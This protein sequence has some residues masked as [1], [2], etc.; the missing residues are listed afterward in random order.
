MLKRFIQNL[1]LRYKL[2][3]IIVSVTALMLMLVSVAYFFH[4]QQ[5]I[6]QQATVE[7][8]TLSR[9]Y[10]DTCSA[11]ITFADQQ[12]ATDLLNSLVAKPTILAAAIISLNGNIFA[13]YLKPNT[14][15][16]LI[17]SILTEDN[18]N[19]LV[20]APKNKLFH[21]KTP[22]ILSHETIG[23]FLIIA[24]FSD[25]EAAQQ[26]FILFLSILFSVAILFSLVLSSRLQRHITLPIHKLITTMG[27]VAK[28]DDFSLRVH[29]VATDEVGQL[30]AGFNTM[31]KRIEQ[32]SDLLQSQK[33]NLHFLATHDALTGLPN[34]TL[35]NDRLH[36]GLSRAKRNKTELAV[37]FI[38]LD[39]FKNINDTMGHDVGDMLL[40]TVANRLK[41]AVREDDTVSRFGGDEFV[42]MLDNVNMEHI[43]YIINKIKTTVKMPIELQ[44][45][46]VVI[47]LSI[48]VSSF[49]QH[50]QTPDEL[51]KYSDVAMY[52]AKNNGRD[53][54]QCYFPDMTSTV[55]TRFNL[56][57]KLH[58]ALAGN[59]FTIHYQPQFDL[60]SRKIHSAEALL[61]WN[62][63]GKEISPVEFIP[64]AEENGLIVPIGRW[65]LQQACQQ[66]MSW[67]CPNQPPVMV[68]V[69]VSARQFFA[70]D[71]FT[72]VENA[73]KESGLPPSCLELEITESMIM[74][75]IE[76]AIS[77]MDRISAMGVEIALDDF[78]TG[79]SSLA[80]LKRF[81]LNKLKIDRT[82]VRN[83]LH[84]EDESAI[85]RAVVS[86][87][88]ALNIDVLA[89]GI[90]TE[91]QLNFLS[92]LDC[93]YGQGFLLSRPIP[94]TKLLTLLKKSDGA[95]KD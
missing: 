21:L 81:P 8:A 92:D 36:K 83:V 50:G 86:M 46:Q 56:G 42:I 77:V 15:Q 49:P 67:Q 19:E 48:G 14:S 90:E 74:T 30:C 63:D 5:V 58:N 34:R 95:T 7:L 2:N 10:S 39:R 57:N 78:G 33:E 85:T 12:G 32:Q 24:D 1:P 79:Y 23:T 87:A 62:V 51:I 84:D 88:L 3:G 52:H 37:L 11:T 47:T 65:V 28:S 55:H 53:S 73:L 60:K 54:A 64:I 76:K 82:F 25:V 22:I 68:A 38:D 44:Q 35:F 41:V 6:K 94:A 4:Q 31:L 72:D 75:D 26:R 43:Q 61:R 17:S 89:E 71:L 91:D 80:Y 9:I 27:N 66:A 93:N 59:E 29:S 20:A 69:N 16:T 18:K 13:N 45:S 70:S 40:K